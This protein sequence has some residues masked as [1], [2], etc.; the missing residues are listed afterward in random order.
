MSQSTEALHYDRTIR[1]QRIDY[2]HE[3]CIESKFMKPELFSIW[4]G[5]I[6][7]NMTRTREK[8]E[9]TKENITGDYSLQFKMSLS[10]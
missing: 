7:S 5:N 3:Y 8:W 10:I 9:L 1:K 2:F 6:S 4:Q